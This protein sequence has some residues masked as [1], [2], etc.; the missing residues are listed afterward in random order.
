V[1]VGE[2]VKF[3]VAF[4]D[5]RRVNTNRLVVGYIS[6]TSTITRE[7]LW[8]E[9]PSYDGARDKVIVAVYIRSL[10]KI[11]KLT[12]PGGEPNFVQVF[13][14]DFSEREKTGVNQRHNKLAF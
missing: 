1:V 14:L 13:F 10:R 9:A 5:T 7:K 6:P 3:V 2:P 11:K 12:T 4:I 8:V